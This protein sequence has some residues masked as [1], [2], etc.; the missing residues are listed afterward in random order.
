[1]AA[2]TPQMVRQSQFGISR[3]LK[4]QFRIKDATR[5]SS[6]HF[7]RPSEMAALEHRNQRPCSSRR[8]WRFVPNDPT[9]PHWQNVFEHVSR[10][11]TAQNWELL[12]V[13]KHDETLRA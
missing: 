13:R 10:S 3:Q 12:L 8:A 4:P 6:E 5:Q 11:A 1:M 7:T 2:T 9:D